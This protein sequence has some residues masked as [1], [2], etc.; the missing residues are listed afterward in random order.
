MTAGGSAALLTVAAGLRKYARDKSFFQLCFGAVVITALLVGYSTNSYDLSLLVLPLAMTMNWRP[1]RP[2]EW[3]GLLAP[4]VP[5]L[6]SPLWF[7]LWMRWQRINLMAVFLLWWL[8]ALIAAVRRL[9]RLREE[10]FAQ[11]ALIAN[12]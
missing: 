1:D 8:F 7:F 3:K 9:R 5:V 10:P 11:S 6:I 12:V 4:A 2:R